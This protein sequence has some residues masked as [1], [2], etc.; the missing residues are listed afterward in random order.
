VIVPEPAEDDRGLFAR[1][2]DATQFAAA[3]LE[4]AVAQCSVSFN[5]ERLTLRGLHLQRPPAEEA[6]LVRCTNG[7][8]FDV[9]LDLRPSSPTFLA[10]EAVELSGENRIGLYVPQGCAHGFL[11]LAPNTEVAYQISVPHAPQMAFGVRWNDPLFGIEWPDR[12][13]VIAPRDAAYPDY[14]STVADST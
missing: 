2:F 6:K 3:G 5:R 13:R 11:T 7:A 14:R 10:W 4:T 1:T 12:P 8:V 9:V